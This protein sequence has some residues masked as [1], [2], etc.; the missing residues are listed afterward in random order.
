MQS[1]ILVCNEVSRY[2]PGLG[3]NVFV[4]VRNFNVTCVAIV[5][6]ISM[7]L[8]MFQSCATS[9]LHSRSAQQYR[10]TSIPTVCV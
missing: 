2:L 5:G 7:L 1:T 4:G 8:K 10:W 3:S 6:C 9:R